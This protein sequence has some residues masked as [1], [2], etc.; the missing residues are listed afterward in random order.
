[1]ADLETGAVE[2]PP[3]PITRYEYQGETL[4]RVLKESCYQFNDLLDAD[5]NLI[6][7]PEGGIT[8]RC[9]GLTVFSPEN[10]EDEKLSLGR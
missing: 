6:G 4:Y 9:D 8:S 7:H 2:F 1:V 5:G 3:Q 10:L